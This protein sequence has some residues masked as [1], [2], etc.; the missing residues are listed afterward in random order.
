MKNIDKNSLKNAFR[1][2][3]SNDIDK[4]ELGTTKGLIE[5][6]YICLMVCTILLENCA[7]KIYRKV[8]LDLLTLYI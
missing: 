6:H 4:I 1:L 2:F 8:V 5:I 3:E 7:P